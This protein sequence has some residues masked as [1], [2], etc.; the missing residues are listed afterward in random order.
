MNIKK[1]YLILIA[2]IFICSTNNSVNA[3]EY[4]DKLTD[5]LEFSTQTKVFVLYN[6]F[7]SVNV[8]GVSGN[9][10]SYSA[11]RQLEADSKNGLEKA[12]NELKVKMEK[13]GDTIIIYLKSPY[14]DTRPQKSRNNN[15]NHNNNYSFSFD[16][17]VRVPKDADIKITTVND[18]DIHVK[19]VH[20][21]LKVNNVNGSISLENILGQTKA[22]T[23]NGEVTAH[24]ATNPAG[25]SSYKSI[26]G[27]IKVICANNLSAIVD[28][29]SMN[30]DF[31]TN[32]DIEYLPNKIKKTE[33]KKH[34]KTVYHLSHKPQLKIGSGK[35]KISFETLNGDMTIKHK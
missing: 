3:Q 11:S 33:K 16:F 29:Q 1:T 27:D 24:Y 32:Y 2:A 8:E 14:I 26:N 35:I 20:G 23:V 12:K 28:Y 10:V 22:H 6:I 19:N 7:G 21:K 30:G 25:N 18:G 5:K 4:N 13:H 15:W 34:S 31:Y 9:T 17:D